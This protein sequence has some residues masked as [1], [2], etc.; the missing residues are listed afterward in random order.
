MYVFSMHTNH[1]ALGLNRTIHKRT[2][3]D[4]NEDTYTRDKN[5]VPMSVVYL[6]LSTKLVV[7]CCNCVDT[8]STTIK[9]WSTV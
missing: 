7:S 4:W 9:R 3:T 2:T 1:L 5:R 8:T 6:S